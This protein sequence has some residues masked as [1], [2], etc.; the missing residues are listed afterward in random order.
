MRSRTHR[1]T[2]LDRSLSQR[3]QHGNKGR[4]KICARVE[5]VFGARTNDMIYGLFWVMRPDQE[6]KFS[7]PFAATTLAKLA[8]SMTIC[9]CF[10]P[11]MRAMFLRRPKRV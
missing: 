2:R 5:H 1:K 11:F 7:V 9:N 10:T 4:L 3:E 8:L 6:A